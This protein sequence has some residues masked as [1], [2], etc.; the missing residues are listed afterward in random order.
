V[1][2]VLWPHGKLEVSAVT[3]GFDAAR[4]VCDYL[5]PD[6][7]RLGIMRLSKGLYDLLELDLSGGLP[8]EKNTRPVARDWGRLE[9]LR[10]DF[11]TAMQ[12]FD[13]YHATKGSPDA[14]SAIQAKCEQLVSSWP[15]R[16]D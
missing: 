14:I 12:L 3:N 7:Q 5:Q 6:K 4:Y 15:T 2:F 8:R 10:V 13:D 1:F 11:A 16:S 9:R